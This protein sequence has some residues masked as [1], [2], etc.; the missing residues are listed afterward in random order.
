MCISYAVDIENLCKKYKDFEL[1]NIT[2]RIPTGTIMGFVGQNGSGKTTTIK[3]LLNLISKDSGQIKIFD[4][5]VDK[6]EKL[7][8]NQIGV[9]FDELGIP[10]SLNIKNVNSIMK[11]IYTNWNNFSILYCFIPLY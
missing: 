4:S 3:A 11:N 1:D 5:N 7:I 2:L 10:D 9:V 8:K 6:N